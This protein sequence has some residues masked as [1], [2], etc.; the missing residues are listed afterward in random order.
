[1]ACAPRATGTLDNVED[2]HAKSNVTNTAMPHGVASRKY[3]LAS[4]DMTTPV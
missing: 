1:M 4:K 3:I 2:T